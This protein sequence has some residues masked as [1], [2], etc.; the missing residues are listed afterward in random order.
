MHG[1][2]IFHC[3]LLTP[4][5]R[6]SVKGRFRKLT[7]GNGK[8]IDRP[9]SP[10]RSIASQCPRFDGIYWEAAGAC[11]VKSTE[12]DVSKSQKEKNRIWK[13]GLPGS[14]IA[15]Y[16]RSH[17]VTPLCVGVWGYVHGMISYI[18]ACW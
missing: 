15:S 17:D 11:Q 1:W 8:V 18:V 6:Y 4:S 10:S 3:G 13:P 7:R 9:T 2:L 14:L 5:A 16:L 12:V